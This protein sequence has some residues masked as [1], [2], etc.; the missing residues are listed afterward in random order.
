MCFWFINKIYNNIRNEVK[1]YKFNKNLLNGI[2]F[3]LKF[4]MFKV[5][6]W[7]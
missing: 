5:K 6:G 4:S 2:M 7:I 1:G 3:M